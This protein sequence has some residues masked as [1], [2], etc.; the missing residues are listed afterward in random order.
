MSKLQ[1][2]HTRGFEVKVSSSERNH[3]YIECGNPKMKNMPYS[4]GKHSGRSV[5]RPTHRHK[6]GCLSCIVHFV[7]TMKTLKQWLGNICI[8]CTPSYQSISAGSHVMG[9][10]KSNRQHVIY[11][12]NLKGWRSVMDSDL[13]GKPKQRRNKVHEGHREG[14][15][16]SE[17]EEATKRGT[18]RNGRRSGACLRSTEGEREERWNCPTAF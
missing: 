5:D 8:Y 2:W 17:K 14:T 3:N 6:T 15:N 9:H 1:A 4:V 11:R 13:R 7:M 12:K 16:H 10:P 18:A